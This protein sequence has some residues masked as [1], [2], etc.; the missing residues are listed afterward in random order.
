VKQLKVGLFGAIG[1]DDPA[2]GFFLSQ[3]KSQPYTVQE[4]TKVFGGITV[5]AGSVVVEAQIY[6][7]IPHNP[8][9]FEPPE[10]TPGMAYDLVWIQ[11]VVRAVVPSSISK[12]MGE[13]QLYLAKPAY[14]SA[15]NKEATAA[16]PLRKVAPSMVESIKEEIMLRERLEL[17][18]DEEL[19]EEDH[20]SNNDRNTT[21]GNNNKKVQRD[22]LSCN[23]EET[24]SEE[25]TDDEHYRP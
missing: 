19:M 10:W 22:S 24:S 1:C 21:N 14:I 16:F 25:E 5:P 9:W 15:Y 2:E 4:E 6:N 3:W 18:L 20:D 13:N 11:H 12:Q 8:G 23:S 7:S 17:E